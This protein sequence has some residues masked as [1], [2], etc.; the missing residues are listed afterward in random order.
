MFAMF[1]V[2]KATFTLQLIPN[3]LCARLVP[4]LWLISKSQPPSFGIITSIPAV[5]PEGT[6]HLR[7]TATVVW[8][9]RRNFRT[10]RHVGGSH[11]VWPLFVCLV[12]AIL[13][14]RPSTEERPFS[15]MKKDRSSGGESVQLFHLSTLLSLRDANWTFCDCGVGAKLHGMS[16]GTATL[17]S[18]REPACF[19]RICLPQGGRKVSQ[20]RF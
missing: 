1:A 14:P 13:R 12:R 4:T 5:H 16:R 17:N 15:W 8:P 7:E 18:K 11:R 3:P 10:G 20:R 19:H 6:I 2:R 9:K